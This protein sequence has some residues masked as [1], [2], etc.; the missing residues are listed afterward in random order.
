MSTVEE[1]EAAIQELSESQKAR[2]WQDWPKL[3]PGMDGDQV[4]DRLLQNPAPR[5]KLS[6]LADRALAE[7]RLNPESF[8][9]TTPEVFA[10]F[11]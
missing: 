4:W 7:H 10:R 11:E 2:L 1:I 6:A 5:P 8:P 9:R 3:F